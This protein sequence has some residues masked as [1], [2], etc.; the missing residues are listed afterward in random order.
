MYYKFQAF[1]NDPIRAVSIPG[2][3]YSSVFE[4][5]QEADPE[6]KDTQEFEASLSPPKKSANFGEYGK[7]R[8]C[9][10]AGGK[11]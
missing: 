1:A 11:R 4:G 3:L 10:A 6:A 5:S 2:A 8:S 9:T 7:T